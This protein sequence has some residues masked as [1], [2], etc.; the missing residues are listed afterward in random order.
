[1]VALAATRQKPKHLQQTDLE[2]AVV[3][4]E[5]NKATIPACVHDAI[6]VLVAIRAE[7][8]HVLSSAVPERGKHRPREAKTYRNLCLGPLE[9][10]G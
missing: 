6:I 5:A 3:W 8:A 10:E 4:V 9:Q 1:M 7:L 2:Q